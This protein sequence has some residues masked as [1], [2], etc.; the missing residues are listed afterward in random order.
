MRAINLGA[1]LYVPVIN[2][3]LLATAY[4]ATPHLRSM[5]ICL[6]DAIRHDQVEQAEQQL[7]HVLCQFAEKEPNVLV[8]VRPRNIEMLGRIL[9]MSS[10]SCVK[11][12]V[13]PKVTTHNLPQWL[14]VL[15]DQSHEFM[16]TIEGEEAFDRTALMR[17]RNQLMPY[18]ERVTAIRIGGNDILGLLGARRSK[19]RTAYEGPLGPVIRDICAAFMPYGF[20]VAAPV[21]EHFASIDVLKAEVALDIEHGL[22]T[23][24]A[25]HP[26]QVQAIH[27]LYRPTAE[28][29]A[30]AKAILDDSAPAVFGAAGSMCEPATH[31]RW[32]GIILRRAQ[33]FGVSGQEVQH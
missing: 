6:E 8:Y 26:I 27:N 32:A 23:K 21:F 16:L 10:V 5:I 1:S 11:G 4:G 18:S 28:E 7:G 14:S 12:F 17:L 15:A 20:Q 9:S 31:T 22:L 19:D 25:I 3:N 13:L 30:E 33:V 29:M 24:S 2:S